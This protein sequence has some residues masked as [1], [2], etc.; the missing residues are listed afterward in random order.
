MAVNILFKDGHVA[1]AVDTIVFK[2]E[3]ASGVTNCVYTSAA[4]TDLDD[5]MDILECEAQGKNPN[6]TVADATG[7]VSFSGLNPGA[8]LQNRLPPAKH[9]TVPW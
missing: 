8:P 1:T 6:T 5:V 7:M 3:K 2:M 4:P 9:P